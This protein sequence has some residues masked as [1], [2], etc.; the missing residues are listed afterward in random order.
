M[1]VKESE[2]VGLKLNIQKTKIMASGPISS[3]HTDGETVETVADFIFLGSKIT[4]DG[5]C[6][7]EIKRRL[8][9]RRKVM[10]NLDSILKSRDITLSTKVHSQGP[11]VHIQGYGFSSGHVW[12]WELGCEESWAPKNWCFWTV[13]LE[14]TLESPLDCKQMQPVHLKGDQSWVFIGRTEAET[15]FEVSNETFI[16]AETPIL[17]PPDVKS[18]LVWKDPDAG[19][20]WGQEEKGTTEDEM[21]GWH[22]RHDGHGFGWTL[23]VGDGQGGLA[24]CGSWSRK[25]S[26]T[27]EWLSGTELKKEKLN[28]FA[29]QE[30]QQ[31]N[32]L[33]T[34]CLSLE[35]VVRSS[36]VIIQRGCDQLMD[37]LLIGQRWVK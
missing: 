19:Q 37:I 28:C 35:R 7:H 16:E 14:K 17:W 13:V 33:I 26:D 12:M 22:H 23:G 6:S 29:G 2:K 34:V 4:A 24:C 21:V 27:T 10:T 5:D 25:E 32:A 30:T 36:E 1:K 15:S 8:L 18:W 31:T 9:L 20:D 11:K 3:W